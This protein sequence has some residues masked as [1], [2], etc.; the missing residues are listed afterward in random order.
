MTRAQDLYIDSSHIKKSPEDLKDISSIAGSTRECFIDGF[1]ID[2]FTLYGS[3]KKFKTS[4]FFTKEIKQFIRTL[5]SG[6]TIFID[7]IIVEDV[8]K[9]KRRI[10]SLALV[11]K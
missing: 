3:G 8:N 11:I 6:D 7:D 1:K 4:N 5:K 2:S 10:E 9:N